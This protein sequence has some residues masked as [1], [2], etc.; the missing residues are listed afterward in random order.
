MVPLQVVSSDQT[1]RF[2]DGV[3]FSLFGP[4]DMQRT[5]QFQAQKRDLYDV[6]TREPSFNGV[7]DPR[8]GISSKSALCK[9]C[10]KRLEECPGHFAYINL[11]KPVF[12][13][14]YIPNIIDILNIICKNCS[15]ILLTPE[16]YVFYKKNIESRRKIGD[17]KNARSTFK[18]MRAETKG[19]ECPHCHAFNHLVKRLP[20]THKIVHQ[21]FRD[22]IGDLLMDDLK[23]KLAVAE[24]ENPELKTYVKN[25]VE[26]LTPVRVELLFKNIRQEDIKLL[27]MDPKFGHPKNFILNTVAVPPICIRPSVQ[28]D[29][30]GSNED[31]LT[32]RLADVIHINN[33]L[34]DSVEKG[35]PVQAIQEQWD[36]LQ[37]T[38]SLFFNSEISSYV[39]PNTRQKMKPSRSLCQRLKGKKGR[40]RGNLS[41]KRVN[42]SGRTVISPDPNVDI[43]QV[44]VP[45]RMAKILTFPEVVNRYNIEVLQECV[46][47]GPHEHPGANSIHRANGQKVFLG[48]G[49]REAAAN[50]LRFGDIVERHLVNDD[51]VLFNRQPSLHTL[52]I[53]AFRAKVMPWRTLRFNECVCS[54]FNADFDGD[55]MNLH[56]PQTYAARAEAKIIMHS[57]QN[58]VTPKNGEPLIACTQDF[59]SAAFLITQKNQFFDKSHFTQFIAGAF[60]ANMKI[61]LPPPAILKPI[62]LW[63]GKQVI[64]T[65]LKPQNYI[66]GST[67]ELFDLVVKERNFKGSSRSSNPVM[68]P[69]DGYV[70]LRKSE[71]MSG[72]IGKTTIGGGSKNSLFYVLRT[73]HGLRTTADIMKRFTKITSRWLMNRGFSIGISDVMPDER[74]TAAKQNLLEAGYKETEEL[75]QDWKA[76]KL[77]PQ[78]GCSME[79]TLEA[80]VNR[81]LSQVRE[82]AG[83]ICLDH[84]HWTNSP[85]I[86]TLS[87]SKGSKINISQMV[88]CVGQQTV[89]GS[90]AP[91]GFIDRT[92]PHF[93]F[94]ARGPKAKGF[95]AN[96]FFTGLE[97]EEMFFHTMAGREGLVDTAVKTAETGYMQRRLMKSLEDLSVRYDGSVRSSMGKMMQLKF[98]VD[99]LD[100]KQMQTDDCLVNFSRVLTSTRSSYPCSNEPHLRSD[101]IMDIVN[102]ELQNNPEAKEMI[103]HMQKDELK[104]IEDTLLKLGIPSEEIARDLNS[105]FYNSLINFIEKNIIGQLENIEDRYQEYDIDQI[106]YTLFRITSTQ[107]KIFLRK[108]LN[109]F[110]QGR[111]EAGTAV[112][113]L[114]GMAI[115]EPCTQMTLKTFH[116]AGVASMNITLGVPR[117]K[118]II[119][120]NN[121]I[122][123]PIITTQ[124]VNENDVKAARI[125]KGRVETT[126][127]GDV[128]TE[129]T[130]VFSG[131]EL[132]LRLV[133]NFKTVANLQLELTPQMIINGIVNQIPIKSISGCVFIQTFEGYNVN[134]E[135]II[136]EDLLITINLPNDPISGKLTKKKEVEMGNPLYLMSTLKS[137]ILGVRI[138]GIEDV[139]RAVIVHKQKGGYELLVEG[140]N[141]KDVLNTPGVVGIATT[142]NHVMEVME[143]LGI[144]AARAT[145][146]NE[147]TNVMSS[148]GMTVDRRHTMLLAD[149]MTCMGTVLG[150]T[151]F[152]LAKTRDSPFMLA[153]FERTT[154][155][156]FA[157]AANTVFDPCSGVSERI[158]FGGTLPL[159]TTSFEVL[160]MQNEDIGVFKPLGLSMIDRLFIENKSS[161]IVS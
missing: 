3:Q 111:I 20:G 15:R 78:P 64:S 55:E 120:A 116:F 98:G 52:S 38:V 13:I 60:D 58:M 57:L 112:G 50:S 132:S 72:N 97:P 107:I 39:T 2:I 139:S 142:C 84:L 18:L 66:E 121:K 115:G 77:V 133:L 94:Y 29:Y 113:A 32:I 93:P 11:C 150:I 19:V 5:S 45:K 144:E 135:A 156:L 105:G 36:Y 129:I 83:K 80:L 128:C 79:E 40:F 8:L 88:A 157:A 86:M 74:L 152:G 104:A 96:S 87:G 81:S 91:F 127:L 90:R 70:C 131:G 30:R 85:M 35:L 114:A 123:T 31:D 108:V 95:V 140:T 122:S 6:S 37:D 41:G 124:L 42:F 75:I 33:T 43:D 61:D 62:E 117:I 119:N 46:R 59:L 69:Y 28:M 153:S 160:Q 12:H 16:R 24:N 118:E 148:H 147:I 47:K 126:T 136:M 161:N 100:P 10:G 130:E 21:K 145:I 25:A 63:T 48:F 149:T 54:P 14:G 7:L 67:E 4:Q 137:Q 68:C 49:N 76:G 17:F 134:P 146:I 143:V 1:P 154:D 56:F 65:L 92:L 103:E 27:N 109:L 89:N 151:R 158:I 9:T 82:D 159:G 125:V 155:H 73:T 71:L 34:E 102:E 22:D 23:E 138:C 51:I 26:V 110:H 99:G 141:F 106:I 101:E 53:M 44:C